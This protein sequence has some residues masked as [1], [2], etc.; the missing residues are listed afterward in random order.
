MK[1][2]KKLIDPGNTDIGLL[3]IRVALGLLMLTHGLPKFAKFFTEEPIAFV[4]VFG[5]SQSLSLTLAVTAEVFCSILVILGLGTRLAAVP[6]ASTMA[7]AAFNV[8]F[9]DPF[10][11]KEMA[12]LYLVGFV[13]IA[14]VGAGKYSVDYFLIKARPKTIPLEVA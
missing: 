12:V 2:L 9:A 11:T 14:I 13:F 5:M 7:V 4:S 8:H 6:V 10:A 1:T 3:F